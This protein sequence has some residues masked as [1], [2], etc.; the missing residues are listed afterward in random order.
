MLH[1]R[2]RHPIP[3]SGVAPARELG[4]ASCPIDAAT[5]SRRSARLM[6]F[7]IALLPKWLSP[8]KRTS[9]DHLVSLRDQ[10]RRNIDPQCLGRP[11]IDD[12]LEVR[13]LL[14]GKVGGLGSL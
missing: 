3:P 7:P 13:R 5:A 9:L 10:H 14:D 1:N 6:T 11:E 4:S 2:R 12:Q 8:A